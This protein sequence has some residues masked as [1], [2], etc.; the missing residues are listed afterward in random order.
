MPKIHP[1]SDLR[2][3]FNEIS[4]ICHQN[5]EPVYITKNGKGDLVVTSIEYFETLQDKLDLY[6]KLSVAEAEY[7]SDSPSISHDDFMKELRG[8][9]YV[10]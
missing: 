1:I 2:N 5:S 3:N 10:T 8:K 9:Y 4:K 6:Q 7:A